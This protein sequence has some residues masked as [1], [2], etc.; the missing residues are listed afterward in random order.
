MLIF[1]IVTIV[2]EI[3]IIVIQGRQLFKL[4]WS[5]YQINSSDTV[6]NVSKYGVFS[7]PY[8]VQMRGNTEQ[9]NSAFGHFS[10]S[11]KCSAPTFSQYCLLN[12]VDASIYFLSTQAVIVVAVGGLQQLLGTSCF[13]AFFPQSVKLV[14][15]QHSNSFYMASIAF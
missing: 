4:T 1:L 7:G 11:V 9:Q 2:L 14:T 12:L 5:R 15:P 8:S 3:L 13:L 6:L 10:R